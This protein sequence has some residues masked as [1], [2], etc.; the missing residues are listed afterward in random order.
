MPSW[1]SGV[2]HAGGHHLD[3]VGVGGRADRGRPARRSPACRSPSTARC[4]AWRGAIRSRSA[5][6]SWSSGTT[7][8]IRPHS[9]AVAASISVAGQRHLERPLAADVAGYRHERR[10]AEQPALAAR[11]REAGRLGGDR[12]VAGDQ[13]AAGGGGQRVHL[14]DHRLG[15]VLDRV[16]HLGAHVEQAGHREGGAGMSPKL[17][18][19]ENTGPLAASITP[20]ASPWRPP[21]TRR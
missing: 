4:R 3:R 17:W 10:V 15:D 9:A 13:L 7:R 20:S 19:A 14:G 18:P 5:A 21:G 11:Q 6:S 1:P 16:H 2:D 8:L 12:E